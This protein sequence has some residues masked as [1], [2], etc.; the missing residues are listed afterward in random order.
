M[1]RGSQEPPA[2]GALFVTSM[3]GGSTIR[4]VVRLYAAAPTISAMVKASG[5]NRFTCILK[6]LTGY[7]G[8]NRFPVHLKLNH[9]GICLVL[10]FADSQP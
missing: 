7:R 1:S 9:V 4:S 2:H 8:L 6:C 10:T 5:N 3:S